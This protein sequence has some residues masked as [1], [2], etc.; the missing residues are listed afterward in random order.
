MSG[1]EGGITASRPNGGKKLDVKQ[2]MSLGGSGNGNVAS[3]KHAQ[4]GLKTKLKVV[5]GGTVCTMSCVKG[6]LV[7][8]SE[9]F[10]VKPH[11]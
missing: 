3:S 5:G 8:L 6:V 11:P 2:S 9:E 1:A 7:C 4:I 10:A